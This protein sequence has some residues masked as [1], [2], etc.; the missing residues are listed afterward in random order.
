MARRVVILGAAGRDFHNFNVCFRD[1]PAYAVVAF[2]ATQI[3]NIAGRVYPPALAGD[4]YPQ[5]IPI[6]PEAKLERLVREQQVDTVVFSYSDVSYDHVMQVGARA[7][8]AGADYWLLG[9][10]QTM[11]RAE[12]PVVA[13]CAARTGAGKS[14]T[15][16]RV[17]EILRAAGQR[18]IVVRHPMPYGDLARQAVQRFATPEDLDRAQVTVE[19]REEYELHIQAGTIVY[20]GID[21][22]AILE[23]AQAEADV[24][25]WD[26]GNN[27]LPFF[28]PDL[29]ITVV[30]P[31]RGDQADR[32]YPG[33]I[34]LRMAHAVIVNKIDTAAW[35][36]VE[37]VYEKI[38]ALNPT[39][40]VI[41]AA[42]PFFVE[43]PAS[44]RGQRV[45]VV[46]DGPTLTHG[47]MAYG[48]GWLA[49]RR[50][51]A[52]EVID[53]RPYAVGA[54]A[55][56]YASYPH[57]GA[58]LPAM[59]YGEDQLADLAATIRR[60]PADLVLIATPVDLRR[61]IEFPQPAQRV[62]YALQEIGEPTL[63]DVLSNFLA[64]DP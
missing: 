10:R 46:E 22:A 34:N 60:T 35:E 25:V 28:A 40:T 48:A 17:V 37:R 43:D 62:S 36:A 2:T 33:E 8:A 64:S 39:A 21:Y 3:P 58:I 26:G 23:A 63:Q 13:V 30:D 24:L 5:G 49:A 45:L 29:H 12:K 59:G 16:R 56:T 27:D 1:D 44:I 9:P 20:A 15:S 7:M 50:Y 41:S 38:W 52:T 57:M 54:L 19:E 14:Q 18:A 47:D 51:G 53:P 4:Q 32:Y 6:E 55:Q 11:L 31:Q 42:S 61:L